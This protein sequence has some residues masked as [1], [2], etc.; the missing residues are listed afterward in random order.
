MTSTP[1]RDSG[2]E[3]T[4][5]AATGTDEGTPTEAT[6]VATAPEPSDADSPGTAPAARP[7]AAAPA[8]PPAAA[9]PAEPPTA[10]E[11]SGTTDADPAAP[12]TP[13]GTRAA[14]AHRASR[15]APT[16]PA[17]EDPLPPSPAFSATG[18]STGGTPTVPLPEGIGR[19]T[20][21]TG[22]PLDAPLTAPGPASDSPARGLPETAETPDP[23]RRTSVLTG[24]EARAAA[25]TTAALPGATTP[26]P[27]PGTPAFGT[28]RDGTSTG[29]S[30]ATIPPGSATA[31]GPEPVTSPIHPDATAGDPLP[32][33]PPVVVERRVGAWQHVAG[34]V[35]GLLLGAVGVWVTLF[36]Q[37]RVLGVQAPTWGG[38]FDPL[39][40][41]LVTA[42]AALLAVV[43]WLGRWTPAVPLTAGTGATLV[44]LAFLYSPA[45]MHSDVVRWVATESTQASVEQTVVAA[46]SGTVLVIGVLLLVAGLAFARGRRPR[47]P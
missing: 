11:P 16:P 43:L 9:A 28:P 18:G 5:P 41:V 17:P 15:P 20:S 8:A 26:A 6:P 19:P 44:G 7:A 10:P 42:G 34:V 4:T 25:I 47:H 1:D 21:T 27:A 31:T 2:Q 35:V 33:A 36:G 40:V 12:T 38:G 37:A 3:P 45:S 22:T 46:T 23:V 29:P 24:P 30:D 13:T 39:G 32:V 14:S